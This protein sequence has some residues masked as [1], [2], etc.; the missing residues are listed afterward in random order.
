MRLYAYCLCDEVAPEASEGGLAQALAEVKGIGDARPH[1]LR[2]GNLFAVVSEFEGARVAVVPENVRAHEQVVAGVLGRQV[3]P[4]PFRFATV[5]VEERFRDYLRTHEAALLASLGRVR[6]CVEMNVKIIWDVQEERRE[7]EQAV[8][9]KH[10]PE[11]GPGTAFLAAKRREISGGDR[12]KER[13]EAIAEWLASSVREIVRESS[14]LVNPA[15]SLVIRAAHLVER[16]H[17][18]EYRARVGALRD[19]ERARDLRFLTSGVW[20]P[21]SFSEVRA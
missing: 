7:A 21:Y 2:E 11:T 13:A 5:A 20:P 9:R 14:V 1:M 15:Q 18:E 6:G 17:L 12:L 19:D 10:T 4:L 16:A 8:E 3:T